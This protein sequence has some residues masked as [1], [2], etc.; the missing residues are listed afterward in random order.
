MAAFLLR[1]EHGSSYMPPPPVGIF[2]D[3]PISD[4]FAKWIEQLF[5]EGITAGCGGNNFCPDDPNTRGQMAV[6]ISKT[7]GLGPP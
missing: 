3:V 5:N 7:F 4:P 2:D 1:A 6:F